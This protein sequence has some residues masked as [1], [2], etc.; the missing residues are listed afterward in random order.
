MTKIGDGEDIWLPTGLMVYYCKVC[1]RKLWYFAN[2]IAFESGSDIVSLGKVIDESTYTDSHHHIMIDNRICIDFIDCDVIHETK[3]SGSIEE[4]GILQLKY[5]MYYMAR[6][7]GQK[8]RGVL[9]YPAERRAKEIFFTEADEEYMEKIIEKI[10][11]IVDATLP[12]PFAMK[13]IC[14]KCAYFDFCAM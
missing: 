6:F 2:G 14:K 4:A 8:Y 11:H 10:K 3:K 1:E 12:P 9:H 5:Y 7:K 13:P